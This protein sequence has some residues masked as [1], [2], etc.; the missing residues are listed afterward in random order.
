M[1]WFIPHFLSRSSWWVE[2]N[3][4]PEI[5]WPLYYSEKL[6]ISIGDT[7]NEGR[8]SC[9]LGQR[10]QDLKHVLLKTLQSYH[11][12]RAQS[13]TNWNYWLGLWASF[14]N[15]FTCR[16]TWQQNEFT[17]QLEF[18]QRALPHNIAASTYSIWS[19]SQTSLASVFGGCQICQLFW[20]G[21]EWT[22]GYR[23]TG[24][25]SVANCSS[26]LFFCEN[27]GDFLAKIR[28]KI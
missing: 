14:H 3:V 7:E 22:I 26:R 27:L 21:I 5:H 6:D 2:E 1:E 12:S 19:L 11:G 4:F 24:Y 15:H 16:T 18:V 9:L 13:H 23:C 25:C 20:D 17:I 8:V 28:A 10:K